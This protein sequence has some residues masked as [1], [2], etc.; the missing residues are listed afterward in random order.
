MPGITGTE[1]VLG[2]L[3]KANVDAVSDKTDRDAL[4]EAMAKAVIDHITANAL[5]SV[6]VGGVTTGVGSTVGSGSIS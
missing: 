6:I 1:S 2:A 5:V 4:F 3:I